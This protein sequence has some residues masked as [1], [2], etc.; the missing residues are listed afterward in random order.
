MVGLSEGEV[1]ALERLYDRYSSLVFSI[2]VRVLTDRQLAEDVTQEVF[3]RLW[4]RP[5]SYDPGR[6]KFR[7]WL[8]SVTRNRSIDERRRVV[9][10]LRQED[11]DDD[12]M[13]EIPAPGRFH[14]PQLEAVLADERRA[15]REAMTRLPPAQREVIELAYFGGLTQVEVAALT[16]EPLGTVK[17]RIRLG[18]QKLRVALVGLRAE[19]SRD[20]EGQR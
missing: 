15:V 8:M 20:A 5:W 7:S 6:G 3:L 19:D 12:G 4:R 9:R 10:R 13:P 17:T 2:A 11:R 1:E 14:D 18:I 16:G